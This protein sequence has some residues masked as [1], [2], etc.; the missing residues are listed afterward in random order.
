[1]NIVYHT[2]IGKSAVY[3]NDSEQSIK[4]L[5]V[6]KYQSLPVTFYYKLLK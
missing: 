6:V 2:D 4:K 5:R 1:M 3:C